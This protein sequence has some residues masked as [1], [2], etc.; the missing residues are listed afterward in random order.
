M[1]LGLIWLLILISLARYKLAFEL[2][3]GFLSLL[4]RLRHVIDASPLLP[5]GLYYQ[6]CQPDVQLHQDGQ[7]HKLESVK[8]LKA[9]GMVNALTRIG[10]DLVPLWTNVI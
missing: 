3:L 8:G 2:R 7:G 10:P 9:K 4:Y 5:N 6:R 1:F